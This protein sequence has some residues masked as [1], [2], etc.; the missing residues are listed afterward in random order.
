[1][2]NLLILAGLSVAAVARGIELRATLKASG[3]R[4]A[5][6]ADWSGDAAQFV[7]VGLTNRTLVVA[8]PDQQD[9]VGCDALIDRA[10]TE[11]KI[12]N[13]IHTAGFVAVQRDDRRKELTN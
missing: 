2:R 11:Q 12:V 6:A 5:T 13:Q 9:V 8:M 7:A 4:A 10:V 1:M 3:A